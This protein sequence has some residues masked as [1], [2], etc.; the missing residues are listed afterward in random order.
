MLNNRETIMVIILAVFLIMTSIGSSNLRACIGQ[1]LSQIFR[2]KIFVVLTIFSLIMVFLIISLLTI[3]DSW[4]PQIVKTAVA[5]AITMGIPL[6]FEAN[7]I[8]NGK[9]LL[10]K[11][12]VQGVGWFVI[13]GFLLNLYQF[14]FWVEA[15]LMPIVIVVALTQLVT[16]RE[17]NKYSDIDRLLSSILSII[18]VLMVVYAVSSVI[19]DP[20]T[21]FNKDNV[22]AFSMPIILTISYLPFVLCLALYMHYELLFMQIKSFWPNVSP[23]WKIR[24]QCIKACDFH[25]KKMQLLQRILVNEGIPGRNKS[26]LLTVIRNF[27]TFV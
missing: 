20:S 13:L 22:I 7:T 24:W 8:R 26:E 15:I 17:N 9:V 11:K 23:D 2:P 16:C 1:L 3:I 25:L 21:L 6:L 14:S 4:Q 12:I 27:N 18:G 10:K 19:S 5:W